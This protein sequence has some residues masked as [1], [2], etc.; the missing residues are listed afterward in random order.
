MLTPTQGARTQG[1]QGRDIITLISQLDALA[2]S[3]GV[4]LTTA[5][6]KDQAKGY[7]CITSETLDDACRFFGLKTQLLLRFKDQHRRLH[8]HYARDRHHSHQHG[9]HH[10]PGLHIQRD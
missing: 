7:N 8:S 2:D 3:H 9:G 1:I 4:T 10:A 5:M 6:R